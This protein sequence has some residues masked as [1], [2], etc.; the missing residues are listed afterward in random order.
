M[1]DYPE[2]KLTT[3][4]ADRSITDTTFVAPVLT[5]MEL[6]HREN[7]DKIDEL[8]SFMS[9]YFEIELSYIV[10]VWFECGT[11]SFDEYQS[12]VHFTTTKD[13]LSPVLLNDEA[14][15]PSTA[16]I[17][18]TGAPSI[19]SALVDVTRPPSTALADIA[20][21][22]STALVD[23]TRSPPSALVDIAKAPSTALYDITRPSPIHFYCASS[24]A[25]VDISRLLSTALVRTKWLLNQGVSLTKSGVNLSTN[26]GVR[27]D[28]RRLRRPL[29]GTALIAD[30]TPVVKLPAAIQAD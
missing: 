1:F 8:N 25:L 11:K 20:R 14:R 10:K 12:L 4:N 5:A 3:V 29:L 22:P 18:S 24:T 17:K 27:L 16:F 15:A 30:T 23:T 26:P 6:W 19:P 7:P 21:P 2:N 13:E 9:D 28:W